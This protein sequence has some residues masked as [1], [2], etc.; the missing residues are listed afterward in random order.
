[1]A[2]VLVLIVSSLMLIAVTALWRTNQDDIPRIQLNVRRLQGQFLA[3]GVMQIARLKF[4]LLPT[5]AYDA[6]T[7]AQGKNPY[8]D[9]STS[10]YTNFKNPL[11]NPDKNIWHGPVFFFG[12]ATWNGTS[13][14]RGPMALHNVTL[15]GMD[16]AADMAPDN[17]GNQIWT[18]EKYLKYFAD[19]ISTAAG[20]FAVDSTQG[21]PYT[22]VKDPFSA[23]FSLP[24]ISVAGLK[25]GQRYNEEAIRIQASV[26]ISGL[27]YGFIKSLD[28]ETTVVTQTAV[29]RVARTR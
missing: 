11:S 5:P 21:D 10:G 26:T 14:D 3:Q 6:A 25:D 12:T 7:Y 16:C 23:T 4:K 29:F 13:Y 27:I 22:G 20:Q 19:D 17:R 28:K 8:F 18:C 9:H 2:L 24:D 1:M 15:S